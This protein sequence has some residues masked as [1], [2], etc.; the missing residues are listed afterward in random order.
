MC[1]LAA[2][3]AVFQYGLWDSTIQNRCQRLELL[4]LTDL[5]SRDYWHASLAAAWRRG[6]GYL[7]IAAIL[8]VALA[9]S[10][11]ARWYEVHAAAMGGLGLWAFSFAVGFRAF[12]TGNQASGVA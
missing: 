9:V 7:A 12:S 10:G 11:R 8:W 3:P 6:R 5:N 1:V 4:L 2:V